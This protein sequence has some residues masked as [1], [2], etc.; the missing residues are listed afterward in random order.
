MPNRYH[1]VQQRTEQ[2]IVVSVRAAVNDFLASADVKRLFQKTQGE[3]C[4]N[5]TQFANWCA[6]HSLVQSKQDSS[7]SVTNVRKSY[8]PIA[9]HKVNAQAVYLFLEHIQT[10]HKPSKA[11][12]E[13]LSSHTLASYVKSIKRLLNWCLEDE[14]YCEHVSAVAVR[15]IKKPPLEETII[16]VFT[17]QDIDAL[18]QAC[19]KEESEHLQVRD[20][21]ILSLLLDSGLRATELC[22][23]ALGNLDLSPDDAHVKVYGKGRK[24]GEVG[25]GE[26]ARRAC[27]KYVRMF[28]E[29]TIEHI[30]AD[31]LRKLSPRQA[32]LAKKQAM[33]DARVFVNRAGKPLTKSGLD[34]LFQRLGEWAG[35]EGV[36]CSPHTCRHWYALNFIRQGGDIYTL[37]KLLRHSSVK[38]TEIYLKALRQAEARRSARS[39]LDHR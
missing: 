27:Q 13:Q 1:R 2:H 12:K 15:K 11:G 4:Y 29:P 18:F 23:L 22:T 10:T 32:Q 20:K 16:E 37:S 31:Q 33:Q 14:Q 7:W 30:I 17:E 8:D 5:L 39:V 25:F 6:E 36:R 21:A 26:Q 24:W 35:I 34:Q 9:L 3:Y 19:Q 38:V 28:R